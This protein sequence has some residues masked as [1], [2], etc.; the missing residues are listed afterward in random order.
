VFSPW[1]TPI[2]VPMVPGGSALRLK[3]P[4]A[5]VRPPGAANASMD[6]V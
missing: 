2:T 3:D 1:P 4:G 6:R 5:R